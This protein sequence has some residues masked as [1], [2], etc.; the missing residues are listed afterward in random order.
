MHVPVEIQV[1]RV[2]VL[3]LLGIGTDLVFHVYRAYRSVFVPK[4][5][6]QHLLDALV[7][8]VTLGAVGAVAFLTN[9]GEVRLYVPLS[10]SGGFLAGE[11]FIGDSIYK[12]ARGAFFKIQR[13]MRWARTKVIEPPKRAARQ[14]WRRAAEAL[15][16]IAPLSEPLDSTPPE[17]SPDPP[18]EPPQQRRT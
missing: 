1:W 6:R 17:G 3:T 4:K 2:A 18:S 9:W 16:K 7:A 12:S 8:L 5:W 14:L 13:G 11:A 10:L 15:A